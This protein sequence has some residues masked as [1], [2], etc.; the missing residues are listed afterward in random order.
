MPAVNQIQ[1]HVG[2]G[3]D[4]QD[5]VSYCKERGVQIQAYSPLGGSGQS[6]LITGDLVTQIG[7]AHG[8]SGVQVALR[9]I[10]E[11]GIPLTTKTSS[12]QHLADDI[13]IFSWSLTADEMSVLNDADSPHGTPSFIMKCS[14]NSFI[15][16]LIVGIFELPF[17]LFDQMENKVIKFFKKM[18]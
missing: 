6:E 14:E 13:N 15:Y 3:Q 4:P 5:I 11:Q 7:Q 8:V 9:W 10:W 18:F 12:S 17:Q 2:M 1:Y 16:D